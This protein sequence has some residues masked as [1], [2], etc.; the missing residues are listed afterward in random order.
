MDRTTT[1]P[2]SSPRHCADAAG[3][4]PCA[5][6]CESPR[7]GSDCSAAV[8]PAGGCDCYEPEAD[9]ATEIEERRRSKADVGPCPARRYLAAVGGR[10]GGERFLMLAD[11]PADVETLLRREG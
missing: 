9:L 4:A 2:D 10:V 5:S 11:G 3:L 1:Y 6:P 7:C 8:C